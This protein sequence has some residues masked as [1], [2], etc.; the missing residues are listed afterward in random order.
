MI[1]DAYPGRSVVGRGGSVVD[2]GYRQKLGGWGGLNL[3]YAHPGWTGKQW[4]TLA[5]AE[6]AKKIE[7]VANSEEVK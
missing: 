4:R 2:K 5:V 3:F 7:V 6:A 1:T